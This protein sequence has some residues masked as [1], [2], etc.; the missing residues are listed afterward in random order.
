MRVVVCVCACMPVCVCCVGGCGW[1]ENSISA[2]AQLITKRI[3]FLLHF[4]WNKKKSELF[5]KMGGH[6]VWG[7]EEDVV[8]LKGVDTHTHTHTHT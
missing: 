6:S 1:S 2:S 4:T 8:V 5:Y 7:G 3:A